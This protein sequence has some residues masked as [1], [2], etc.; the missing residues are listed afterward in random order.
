MKMGPKHNAFATISISSAQRMVNEN[1]SVVPVKHFVCYMTFH[2][3][4]Q[5]KILITFSPVFS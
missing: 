3:A 5:C 4:S 2:R 1:S